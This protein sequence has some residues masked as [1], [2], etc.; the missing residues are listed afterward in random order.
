[1]LVKRSFYASLAA[2]SPGW[3]MWASAMFSGWTDMK[4]SHLSERSRI[5]RALEL[6]EEKL[7]TTPKPVWTLDAAL[8]QI[9]F[10]QL[11]VERVFSLAFLAPKPAMLKGEKAQTT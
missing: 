8:S 9:K 10:P 2:E 3:E 11:G 6:W 4:P 1:M 5:E 7:R